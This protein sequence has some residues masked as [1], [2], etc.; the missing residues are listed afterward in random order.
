MTLNYIW[1]W[2]SSPRA[3]GNVDNPFIAITP[4]STMTLVSVRVSSMGQ[5]ELLN[6]LTACK[7]MTDVKFLVLHSNIS[8]YLT[9]CKQVINIR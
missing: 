8:N 1:Q 6:Y 3:L 7:Q 4:K 9:V 5:M 2:G